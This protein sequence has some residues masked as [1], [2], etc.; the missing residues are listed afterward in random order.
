M[1][2]RLRHWLSD[3]TITDPLA[4]QQVALVQGLFI[5]TIA[6]CVLALPLPFITSSSMLSKL[7]GAVTAALVG[8][9][10]TL[11][12][13]IL[14]R[15]HFKL[16]VTLIV[17]GMLAGITVL[18]VTSEM[19]ES[20]ALLAFALPLT[21]AGLLLDRRALWLVIAGCSAIA[22][23]TV[24]LS[25][26]GLLPGAAVRP[27]KLVL[28][29]DFILIVALL[30]L[31]VD[32]IGA[33]FHAALT[34]MRQREH[35]LARE[36]A[37]RR[38]VELA[39]RESEE[40]YRLITENSSDLV[41]LIDQQGRWVY[42]T[43]SH[44]AV[45]GFDAGDL[46][47]T[48]PIDLVHPDDRPALVEQLRRSL[49]AGEIVRSVF[50]SRHADGGWRWLEG[51]W[52]TITEDGRQYMVASARDITERKRLELQL[53]QAQ[54]LES[55]GRLAGGIAH[56]FNNLL[57]AILGNTELALETLPPD[58]VA[59]ADITE[60]VK[61]ANRASALTRQLLAFARKQIIEPHII[62]LNQ[63]ILEM[64]ALLRRLI[65]EDIDLV[66]LPA[67]DLGRIRA[68]PGQIEQVIVNLAVNA[69]DA[70]PAG[71]NLTIETHN[72][73]LDQDYAQQHVSAAPGYYVM[74]AVSDTGVGMDDQTLDRAFEPFFTTKEQGR[75]TGLGLAMCY[76]IVKQH[77]GYIWAYSEPGQGSTFKIYLPLVDAPPEARPPEAESS[78]TPRG[79]ETILLVEDEPAVRML[80]A[81]TL[82]EQGYAVIEAPQGDAALA[83]AASYAGGTIDLLL[84]DVVMPGMSGK[85][86]A[87][88]L[89]RQFPTIRVLYISGYTDNAIV[90]QGRLDP[91]VAF[92]PK[93]FAPATLAR[94]VREVLD[95]GRGERMP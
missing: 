34:A 16:A 28:L 56:D 57:T 55:I 54:R 37:E 41:S 8:I 39:L 90:H 72:I 61:A 30:G 60:I 48:R 64:D 78:A 89:Q 13:V 73:L 25:E 94:K 43:P 52:N 88:A 2:K 69:R 67:P 20:A 76:G 65:G 10:V 1:W 87:E 22:S 9:Y 21:L 15:G 7:V 11:A 83:L 31:V 44:Q 23:A 51:S 58:H 86:L 53:V 70:M 29:I 46:L 33:A 3:I 32:R 77:G 19:A 82:R 66:T 50:R 63:L 6:M 92:L 85:L 91:G 93:P 38:T 81:R 49:A 27:P 42:V 84:T 68:D 24:L 47:G 74:L 71:G 17:L 95:S 40:R 26:N 45:L 5:G 14:R 80:A 4:R 12:L 75:G 79:I 59:H 35:E 36:V 62:D 18:I